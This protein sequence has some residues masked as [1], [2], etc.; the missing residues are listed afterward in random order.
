[1]KTIWNKCTFSLSPGEYR[2]LKFKSRS[3]VRRNRCLKKEV[4]KPY[5]TITVRTSNVANH[6][7]WQPIETAP[8]NILID[9]RID[10]ERGCRNHQPLIKNNQYWFHEKKTMY[11][12]YTPTHWRPIKRK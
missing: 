12:Y 5:E 6:S 10:D 2:C 9:T 4:V 3:P 7:S 8:E 11:V 1:M